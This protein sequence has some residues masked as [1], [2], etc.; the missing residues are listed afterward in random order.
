MDDKVKVNMVIRFFE[1]WMK[2][3]KVCS[4]GEEIPTEKHI[5]MKQACVRIHFHVKE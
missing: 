5:I 4:L 3:D 1:G 2:A